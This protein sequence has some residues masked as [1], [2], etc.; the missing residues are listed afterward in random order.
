M[1]RV[2]HFSVS[3]CIKPLLFRY[4]LFVSLDCKRAGSCRRVCCKL[5]E[6]INNRF[7]KGAR[8]AQCQVWLAGSV[9]FNAI[10]VL[11]SVGARVSA[12]PIT[13]N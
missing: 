6:E 5:L 13:P 3:A 1:L 4:L 12:V 11:V 9:M 10:S 8:I 2:Q 7:F